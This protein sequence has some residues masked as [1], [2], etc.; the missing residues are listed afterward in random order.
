MPNPIRSILLSGGQ[1]DVVMATLGL[2]AVRDLVPQAI[3]PAARVYTRSVAAPTAQALLPDLD[4]RSMNAIG[5][6]Q[7]R[8]PRPRYYASA[9]T[10]WSTVIRNGLYPDYYVHFAA[11][12]RRASFG[13]P[14]PRAAQRLQT[15]LNHLKFGPVTDWRRE[16]PVYTRRE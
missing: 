16:I 8:P 5:K 3:A 13:Q 7:D 15:W 12:R 6:G 11:H 1:G 4:V 14:K 2:L 9:E 10:S